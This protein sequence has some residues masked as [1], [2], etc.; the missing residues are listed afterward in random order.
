LKDAGKRFIIKGTGSPL[1]Q[2]IFSE[3]LAKLLVWALRSYHDVTPIML[4]VDEKDEVSIA[5]AAALILKYMHYDGEVEVFL[6][7]YASCLLSLTSFL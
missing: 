1:R 3:D 4:S 2:F 7:L 5:E 6:Y